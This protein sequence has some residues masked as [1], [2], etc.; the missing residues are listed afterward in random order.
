MSNRQTATFAGGCFWCF[1]A[2]FKRLKGVETA[3]SGYTGGKIDNPSYEEVSSGNTGHAEAVQVKFDPAV[4]SY[5][6]LVEVFFRLHDPTT[7]NQQG[8]DVGEQY[9]SAIFYHS[10]SQKEIA[11]KIME[12]FKSKKVYENPIVTEILPLIKFNKAEKYHQDYYENNKNKN[13]Y[14][15]IVIDPKIQKLDREFKN[16]A[17]P[18]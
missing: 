10:E 7:L 15:R 14:C 13:P 16:I 5:G 4:I 8:P 18:E 1:E 3:V 11:E 12:K 2:I 9:R 17:K 6:Q